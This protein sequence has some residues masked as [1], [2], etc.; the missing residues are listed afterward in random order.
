VEDRREGERVGRGAVVPRD[1]PV[2]TGWEDTE[3][4]E[5]PTTWTEARIR[6]VVDALLDTR[7][8]ATDRVELEATLDLLF[9]VVPLGTSRP[10]DPVPTDQEALDEVLTEGGS[11]RTEAAEARDLDGGLEAVALA[12]QG[13]P[14]AWA[15]ARRLDEWLDPGVEAGVHA[16]CVAADLDPEVVRREVVSTCAELEQRPAAAIGRAQA[17]LT[18]PTLAAA[19]L[20]RPETHA[21]LGVAQRPTCRDLDTEMRDGIGWTPDDATREAV[22]AALHAR[23]G[24]LQRLRERA[25]SRPHRAPRDDGSRR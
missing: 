4:P 17:I 9:F 16:A 12:V 18:H 25:R 2:L 7:T 23:I 1:H 13:R 6:Q 15:I 14:R 5:D 3:R 19:R 20:E 11:A 22:D 21:Q 10:G 8:D 24:R